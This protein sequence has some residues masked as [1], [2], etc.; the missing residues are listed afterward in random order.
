MA[1]DATEVR[2]QIALALGEF[3]GAE[4]ASALAVAVTD[5]DNGVAQAAADRYGRTEGSVSGRSHLPNSYSR[6]CIC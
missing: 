4:T 3:D 1:D 5:A 2:L 6:E